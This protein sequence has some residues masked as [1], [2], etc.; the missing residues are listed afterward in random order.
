MFIESNNRQ[1]KRYAKI[2]NRSE[3]AGLQNKIKM[4]KIGESSHFERQEP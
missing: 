4:N 2:K 3:I 1:F